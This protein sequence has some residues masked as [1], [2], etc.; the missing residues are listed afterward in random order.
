ML[1]DDSGLAAS[2]AMKAYFRK[3][4][5]QTDRALAIARAA[6]AQGWD[7]ELRVEIPVAHDLAERVEN[8][9]GPPGV[10]ERIRALSRTMNREEVSIA[11]AREVVGKAAG[12][13]REDAVDQAVRTG[14]A[15]LT[16]GVLVAPLEGMTG[17]KI[18]ENADGSE[19]VDLY[20]SG[21]IRAAGGTAQALSVLI[22][23]VVRRELKIGAYKP[24]AREI[25]RFKEE[26]PAYKTAQHL[27]YTPTAHEVGVIVSNMPVSVNGEGTEKVEVSGNRDLPRVETNRLR[28]G[29]CL[30]IAEGLCLKAP[31]VLKHVRRLGLEGWDFLEQLE[32][33]HKQAPAPPDGAASAS[34]PAARPVASAESATTSA[35][36]EGDEEDEPEEDE[37]EEGA[38]P[39]EGVDKE[40]KAEYDTRPSGAPQSARGP[41]RYI[42]DLIAGRPVFSHPS[43]V[44]GFRLRYGR[45]RTTGLAA[46]AVHPAT[47]FVVGSFLAVGT[48]M[49]IERP[50]KA[51]AVTPCDTIEGPVVSLRNGDVVVLPT[52]E[53]FRRVEREVE[54]ILDLGE[55]LIPVGEF[56]ENNK[57]LVPGAWCFEWWAEELRAKGG[58][59]GEGL[60]HP[61]FEAALAL[62]RE[63][64]VGLHPD[65]TLFW[66]DLKA[67]EVAEIAAAFASEGALDAGAL[68]VPETPGIVELLRK[69]T[70]PYRRL[71]GRLVLDVDGGAVAASLG[72]EARDG[73]ALRQVRKLEH[74]VGAGAPGHEAVS[75]LL[76][77]PVRAKA[78]TRIGA[79]MGRPEKARERHMKPPV[80]VLFPLGAAG[81]AQ[82]LVK[83]AAQGA[84]VT[85]EVAN[86]RCR[87][88][89][90]KWPMPRCACGGLTVQLGED[91]V[92]ARIDV[93]AMLEQAK[94]DLKLRQ[95]PDVKAVRGLMSQSRIPESLHKGVL[96]A[97]H[98]VTVFRDGT[99]RFDLTDVPVTHIRLREVGLTPTRAKDLGYE[100]D[101]RGEPLHSAEQVVELRP[102]DLV[103]SK[104]CGEYL[105]R[106]AAF[107]DDELERL[108]RMEPY[109]RGKTAQDLV[110]QL[111]IGL[112]PHTSGGVLGRIIGFT[113]SFVAYA[114]PFFHAA[115][116]RNCDG[117][118]DCVMLLLDGFLNFSRKFLPSSR[119]GQMDAPLVLSLRI[120]P[121]EI[122]KEAHAIDVGARYPLALFEAAAAGRHPNE[123]I[124]LLDTVASRIGTPAQYEG[125]AFTHD[126]SD[127]SAGPAHS[128]Y[129]TMGSMVDKMEAQLGLASRIR[130]VDAADVAARVIETHFLPDL[131]GNLKA[132]SRQGARCASPACGRKYRRIPLK[133]VC[134]AC[135]GDLTLLVHESSVKKYL[136]VTKR[137]AEQYEVPAYIRQRV[138]LAEESIHALF[139]NDKVRRAKLDDFMA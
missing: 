130:A 89:D 8:L 57:E 37:P 54:E 62:S 80:H 85:V 137:M 36:A 17:V 44:G 95:L 28:G 87:S 110:G 16:E 20:F 42:K 22:A 99:V 69:L 125:F 21:P 126:T 90:R 91:P 93:R 118:E 115:K 103:L 122:D 97:R 50:G 26:I 15:I 98:Q 24:T 6:R 117:D 70:V 61:P 94:A 34:E 124:K 78:P 72:L 29:P 136:E 7:P 116:R 64:G 81:G 47:M 120:D 19:Y 105:L 86:R 134:L 102:Q 23:D 11:V 35:G 109:Y 139:E 84:E 104:A 30:V 1:S 40:L 33:L 131:V 14:L 74:E 53:A 106:V 77:V 113:P 107:I 25:E 92:E 66:H 27:Q 52:V 49:K 127:I 18:K 5:E 56:V 68:S 55:I 63:H 135:G 121:N 82:R 128:A 46:V 4:E 10:A 76:G 88:C 2:P 31:K 12:R 43:R 75:F 38:P 73:G 101:F 3:L 114:H 32:G 138:V 96:R 129:S 100:K 59:D 13:S 60:R 133:G 51:G 112:A 58:P 41:A 39:E 79:R 48:Q 67:A 65:F 132:F 111:V 123:V 83:E 119:G 71:A 45:A 9:V 108:Y